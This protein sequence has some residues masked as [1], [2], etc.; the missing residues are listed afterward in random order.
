MKHAVAAALALLCVACGQK[1]A[2]YLPTPARST[3]PATPPPATPATPAD[4]S[5]STAADREDTDPNSSQKQKGST[6]P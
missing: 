1:G 2:L 5:A 3:V 4:T 6:A